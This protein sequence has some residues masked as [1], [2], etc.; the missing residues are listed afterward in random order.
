M[1]N[2]YGHHL[3]RSWEF[4]IYTVTR[5]DN[6]GYANYTWLW[7]NIDQLTNGQVNIH[8]SQ[9]RLIILELFTIGVQGTEATHGLFQT[10]MLDTFNNY[11]VTMKHHKLASISHF[12]NNFNQHQL[13]LARKKHHQWYHKLSTTMKPAQTESYQHIKHHCC[14]SILPSPSSA[15]KSL[16]YNDTDY[17]FITKTNHIPSKKHAL[18]T[19]ITTIN[20]H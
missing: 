15:K 6:R 11:I 18:A 13:P 9:T 7:V 14:R 5:N 12:F 16:T 4:G 8:N 1:V 2:C 10:C 20:H 19:S 3:R 17:N